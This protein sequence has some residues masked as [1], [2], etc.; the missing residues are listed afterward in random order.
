MTSEAIEC[1]IRLFFFELGRGFVIFC[2][3]SNLIK[4]IYECYDYGTHSFVHKDEYNLKRHES[5]HKAR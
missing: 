2:L 4:I 5:S 3:N 1:Y